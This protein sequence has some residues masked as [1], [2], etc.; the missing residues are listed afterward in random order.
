MF[1]VF[2]HAQIVAPDG[3]DYWRKSDI[4]IAVD[5]REERAGVIKG[6][7]SLFFL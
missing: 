1:E 7:R 4:A 5:F 2:Q 6:I 3:R